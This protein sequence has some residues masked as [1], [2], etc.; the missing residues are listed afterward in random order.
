MP[1]R[2]RWSDPEPMA[3]TTV[4]FP[5][6][7]LKRARMRAATDEITIQALLIGALDAELCRREKARRDGRPGGQTGSRQRGDSP[8][9]IHMPREIAIS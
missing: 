8:S 7:L 1:P 3:Q 2:P 4:R 9:H 6:T 5:R